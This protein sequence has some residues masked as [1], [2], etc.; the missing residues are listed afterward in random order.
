MKKCQFC[1]DCHGY[2]RY[3]CDIKKPRSNALIEYRCDFTNKGILP[4]RIIAQSRWGVKYRMKTRPKWCPKR[5]GN[6]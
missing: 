3:K 6:I 1:K 2:Y 4:G 5:K